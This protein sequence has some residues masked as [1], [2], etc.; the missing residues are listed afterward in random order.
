MGSPLFK[1]LKPRGTSFYA[2]P[3]S[4]QDFNLANYSQYYKINF[5]KFALL[6]FPKVVN[7]TSPVDGVFD[8]LPKAND[9]SNPFY[10]TDPN[11]NLPSNFGDQLVESLRN[12][13]ANYDTA[14]HESR[15]N[16]NT[17]FYNI[18]ER[19]TPTE[20]IFWKW[21]RKL[22]LI[23]WEPAVH[24]V[25]WDKNLSD[26]DNPNATTSTNQ[27]YFRKYAWKEREII[28]YNVGKIEESADYPYASNTPLLTI[29][30]IVKYKIGDQIIFSG[31]TSLGFSGLTTGVTYSIGQILFNT[32]GATSYVWL[33]VPF[34]GEGY[35]YFSNMY[36]F[37]NYNRL[38]EYVGEINSVSNIQTASR[39][40]QEITAY[41]PHQAGK[42]PTILFGTRDN[43]NYYPGLEIPLL[44]S[45]IQD[46]IYGAESLNCPIRSDPQDYPGSY[47]GQFDTADQTYMS[48]DGD[49]LRYQGD[50]YG[51][52]LTNNTGLNGD[53]YIEKLTDFDSS[54]I[55]GTFM[56]FDKDHYYKMNIPNLEVNNF[57]EFNSISIEGNAPDDFDF[58]AILWYYELIEEDQDHNLHSYVNL[59]GIEFLNN[60]TNDDDLLDT[61]ITPYHKLVT[62]GVHDG[63]S[64]MFNLNVHY[65][66]DNDILPLT[67]DP[68]TIYNMFGFDMYNDMM[69]KLY[70]V[71][72]NFV[73]IIG[74]FIRIN[75]D[76]QQMKTII[77]SQSDMDELK[78]K[79]NNMESLLKLYQTNQLID[80]DTAKISVD[81]SGVYPMLKVNV[82][83]VEYD[84][85]LNLSVSDV[86]NYNF[87]NTG[88][89][90]PVALSFT[91]KML[92]NIVNNNVSTDSGNVLIVFDRELRN[93]QRLDII[94]RPEYA[95]YAQRLY[96]NMIFDMNN[97]KSLINIFNVDLP[98]DVTSYNVSVPRQSTFTNSYFTN[99]NIDVN[100]TDV[101]TGVS[102]CSTGF[103]NLVLTEDMFKSGDTVYVQN[104]YFTDISGNTVDFSG[105][106][107]ILQ[108][109]GIDIVINL[110]ASV[111]GGYIHRSNPFVSYY[112]GV[113][114]SILRV[115]GTNTSTFSDRYDI[116]YKII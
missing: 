41:I 77:Y 93:K 64:Y 89:S 91:N 66:I 76:I 1:F 46:E 14:L 71:N 13:V 16:K 58:N 113:Q 112:R 2:W 98:T 8:F 61:L 111:V 99:E 79:M 55:D 74:E 22:N 85:I 24:K 23:D 17:D 19:Y 59:Y 92:I 109:T 73:N 87:A 56:D 106:Y 67:Y 18:G 104:F 6:N 26:F 30:E 49:K 95:Q 21:C 65:N 102:F 5:T 48:S 10:S 45:E 86:Y 60:P 78:S 110:N 29:N 116:S 88:A 12:Y 81:N 63:L 28:H 70:Q 39:V 57:D 42:S 108:K 94:V 101:V 72:E 75:N 50:Y 51:V 105:A 90:Y 32:T 15:I 34:N 52:L 115:D 62:N 31:I 103:T 80:S 33:D 3:S 83:G 82:V 96:L 7:G 36:C 97:T 68:S 27:D 40:G 20:H 54:N 53:A 37:L 11:T 84:Q 114:I 107:Q 35:H 100:T 69:S 4:A 38:V 25:D 44:S 47:Y 9:G 43:T